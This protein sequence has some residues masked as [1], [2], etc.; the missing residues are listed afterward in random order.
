MRVFTVKIRMTKRS[1]GMTITSQNV[2]DLPQVAAHTRDDNTVDIPAGAKQMDDHVPI[3][4]GGS[5]WQAGQGA[6]SLVTPT[7]TN[8]DDREKIDPWDDNMGRS[9]Y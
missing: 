6:I 1:T 3:H 7:S 9:R 8:D 5:N 2:P 4:T